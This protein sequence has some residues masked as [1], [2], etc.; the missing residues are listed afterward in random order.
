MPRGA[1]GLDIGCR[2]WSSSGPFL[3]LPA[4]RMLSPVSQGGCVMNRLVAWVRWSAALVCVVSCDGGSDPA[5]QQPGGDESAETAVVSEGLH[6]C[7]S[8]RNLVC[9]TDG[10][11]YLNACKA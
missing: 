11:T 8:T 2:R 4:S 7:S 10:R 3:P 5:A 6:H 1:V 9:G